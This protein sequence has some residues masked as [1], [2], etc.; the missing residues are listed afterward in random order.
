[1][2]VLLVVAGIALLAG[3]VLALVA[4]ISVRQLESRTG[5]S[6]IQELTSRVYALEQLVKQLAS[7]EVRPSRETAAARQEVPQ[8]EPPLP[9]SVEP[10]SAAS[11]MAPATPPA[12]T[13]S[14][15][16]PGSGGRSHGVSPPLEPLPRPPGTPAPD[17]ESVIGGRWLNRIGIVALLIAVSYFLKL[18][19]DNNWIG[20]TGR[21][22]V[23]ILLGALMLPWS[24]WL[25]GRG[26]SYFSDGIA[27]LGE[28]TLFLSLWAGCQY[29][30]LYSRTVG[31]AAMITVT[32]VMAAIAIGRNSQGIAVMS[33]LG[34]LLA[35]VLAS[36][37]KDEQLVLFT[38]LLV[39]GAGAL[40]MAAKNQWS[41]LQ[42]I[43]FVGTQLYFWGWYNQFF[44]RTLP[45]ER[46]VVFASL[47]FLLY[48]LLPV[49][50]AIEGARF[51]KVDT[52]VVLLNEFA[53]SGALF[54]LLWPNDKWP[55]TLL[56]V[57]LA[58]AHV[59][60]ARLVPAA[61][62]G[63]SETARLL[64]AGLALTYLTAAIPVRF[65]GQWITLCFAAE[66]AILV[67]TGFRTVSNFLRQAG[68]FLLAVAALRLLA[69]PPGGGA[70][71]FNARFAQFALMIACF[72]V[73]LGAARSHRASI[74]G[75]EQAEIGLLGVAIN[76]Y[77]LIALSAEFWDYFG[78]ATTAMDATLARHLSLSILWTGYATA[79]ILFGVQNKSAL[80]R[81]QGLAL[82]GLVVGKVF[83]YDL[84]FL[85]RAYRILSFLV[86]G[87]V[88][89]GVS[90]LYQRKLARERAP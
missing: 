59:G 84:S 11:P 68:Y 8:A 85:E 72:G 77:A 69:E 32:A 76:V 28:A 36:S 89:L 5:T 15:S 40:V 78:K 24:R 20:P 7:R 47:F 56:F 61:K 62:P 45:L 38:Y 44:H 29:Y 13:P 87:A 64:F 34:G 41:S 50:K 81:W 4:L 65:E 18:A 21:V 16:L 31:F 79:L 67:W 27:A 3:P 58:A 39:L 43:A 90:F 66:G 49:R 19:F 1:M 48:S 57:A 23:G 35:P 22:A 53:F 86:L 51:D 14:F 10:G 70:L 82:F 30:S 37:G 2:D 9:S 17:L 63:P 83:L 33:L 88:L 25:Y 75:R 73:A 46:T 42:P 71:F 60:V 54:V 74:A 52:V 80:M 12:P 26:Y 6:R 55:L